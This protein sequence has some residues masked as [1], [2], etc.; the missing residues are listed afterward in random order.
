V[1]SPESFS[2]FA[3]IWSLW[4]NSSE[5]KLKVELCWSQTR[6]TLTAADHVFYFIMYITAQ[7]VKQRNYSHILQ[8]GSFRLS[9]LVTKSNSRSAACFRA[10]KRNKQR[11]ASSQ[12]AVSL[13]SEHFKAASWCLWVG[14]ASP[15]AV[16]WCF[17]LSANLL[18]KHERS[19]TQ[20]Q[21]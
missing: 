8:S 10:Q 3:V 19:A 5:C 2:M 18:H 20:T 21:S 6:A 15:S 14:R 1:S 16:W 4:I 12:A 9:V 17:V 11:K 13:W 7:L